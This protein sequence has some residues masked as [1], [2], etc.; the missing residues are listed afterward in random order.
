MPDVPVSGYRKKDGTRVRAH[1]RSAPGAGL[2]VALAVTLTVAGVVFA[3]PTAP[4]GPGPGSV[5]KAQARTKVQARTT[6]TVQAVLRLQPKGY[7]VT[8][9]STLDGSDC[10]AHSYGDVRAF[11]RERPCAALSRTLFEV[12]DRRRNVV[13]VAVAVVAMPDRAGALAYRRLVDRHG[14]GNVTELSRER[15]RYRR[16]RFTGHPY[17]SDRDGEVVVNVQ[18]QPVARG[19]AGAVLAELLETAVRPPG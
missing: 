15:G 8:S 5:T 2:G 10:A 16:V 13:L 19:P 14:T 4:P 17:A 6:K 1:T 3:G 9:R 11:F 18:A 7:Q 12:R